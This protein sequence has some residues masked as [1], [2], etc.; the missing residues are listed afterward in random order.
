MC[1]RDR[2]NLNLGTPSNGGTAT[3]DSGTGKITWNLA[4]LTAAIGSSELTFSATVEGEGIYFNIAEI[5]TSTADSDSEAN[6]QNYLEDDIA[7]ACVSVPIKLCSANQDSILVSAPA[8]ATNVQ[9]YRIYDVG[10]DGFITVGDTLTLSAGHDITCLLYTSP[11]P[12][13]KRQ[14]RMPSS[15]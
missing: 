3:Y 13:D 6:N 12:R 5:T 11:S 14:S 8:G 7:A 15:A 1:I 9:W 10:E 4:D 2:S